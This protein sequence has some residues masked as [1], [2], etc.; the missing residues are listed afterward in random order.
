MALSFYDDLPTEPRL[1]MAL[2]KDRRVK[3]C[4]PDLTLLSHKLCVKGRC[5]RAYALNVIGNKSSAMYRLIK[6]KGIGTTNLF[7]L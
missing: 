3:I 4:D 5:H 7:G 2:I 1:S 6:C